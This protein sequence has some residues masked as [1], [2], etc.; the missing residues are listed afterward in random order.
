MFVARSLDPGAENLP[1]QLVLIFGHRGQDGTL[2]RRSLLLQEKTVI[3]LS[4]SRVETFD[5]GGQLLDSRP[6]SSTVRQIIE[7]IQP[8]EVYYLAAAHTSA[9]GRLSTDLSLSAYQEYHD[10]AVSQYLEVLDSVSSVSRAT[11]VFYAG[12]S[13]VFGFGPKRRLTESSAFRPQSLYAM[14][15]AQGIW[16]TQKYRRE[17]GLFV[18]S[19][20]LFNHEST[21]RAENFFSARLI[22]SA[23]RIAN[24]SDEELLIG[25]L[26]ARADWGHAADFVDAFQDIIRADNPDDFVVATGHTHSVK[27]FVEIVFRRVG[28][29]WRNHVREDRSRISLRGNVEEAVPSKIMSTTSWRPQT[30]FFG[31]VSRLVDDHLS[32]LDNA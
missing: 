17:A 3:G 25:S 7:E 5:R 11:R 24:G 14:S 22:Q 19:G 31:F 26:E 10:V 16:L 4:R 8:S 23:I 9:E 30:D 18:S 29:D 12:S 6:R 21:L 27:D 2:L 1:T 20:I 28:L 32:V 15:K 13:H